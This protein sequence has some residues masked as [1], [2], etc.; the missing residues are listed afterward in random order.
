MQHTSKYQFTSGKYQIF[1]SICW[2]RHLIWR[3]KNR[4]CNGKTKHPMGQNKH[5]VYHRRLTLTEESHMW[6]DIM[7]GLKESTKTRIM[8]V[9]EEA[10]RTRSMEKSQHNTSEDRG[11]PA[12]L[13]QMQLKVKIQIQIQIQKRAILVPCSSDQS[14]N[15]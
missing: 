4:K 9:Q 11:I 8:A 15:N 5:W 10:L 6:E 12:Q 3:K 1:H 7:A 13:Q 14:L 2:G